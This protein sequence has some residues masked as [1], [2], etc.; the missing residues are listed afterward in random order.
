M[1]HLI[2]FAILAVAWTASASGPSPAQ[3]VSPQQP[4]TGPVELR[5][6]VIVDP[7][8]RVAYVMNPEGG[9]DAIGLGRGELLWHSNDAARFRSS[10]CRR[11]GRAG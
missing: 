10:W 11:P 4:E 9:S 2:R 1:S 6:G 8:R 3:S 7:Q 5:P